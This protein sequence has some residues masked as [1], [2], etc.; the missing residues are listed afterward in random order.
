MMKGVDAK[1]GEKGVGRG[2]WGALVLPSVLVYDLP[3]V[4]PSALYSEY[5]AVSW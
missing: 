3:D 4:A 5:V 1:R 2:P